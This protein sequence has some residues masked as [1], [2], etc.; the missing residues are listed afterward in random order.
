MKESDSGRVQILA[1]AGR[2][3]CL[4]GAGSQGQNGFLGERETK[5]LVCAVQREWIYRRIKG[6]GSGK[7][8]FAAVCGVEIKGIGKCH[9]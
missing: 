1:G 3:Q 8:G 6:R 2:S 5:D 7:N 9:G 4:A